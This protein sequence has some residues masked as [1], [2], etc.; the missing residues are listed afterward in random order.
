MKALQ[1]EVER[2]AKLMKHKQVSLGYTR[3]TVSP[4]KGV[5]PENNLLL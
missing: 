4:W 2:F 5:Q 3:L 1:K